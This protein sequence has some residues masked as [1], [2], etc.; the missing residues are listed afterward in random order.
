MQRVELTSEGGDIAKR[1]AHFK[2]LVRYKIHNYK[3]MHKKQEAKKKQKRR[4]KKMLLLNKKQ[5]TTRELS[6]RSLQTSKSQ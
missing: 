3:K 2:D 1:K 4:Q 6:K 5:K